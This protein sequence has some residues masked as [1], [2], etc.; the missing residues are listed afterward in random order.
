M[1]Y[2]CGQDRQR[3]YIPFFLLLFGRGITDASRTSFLVTVAPTVGVLVL[4]HDKLGACWAGS[5][6]YEVPGVE[7]SGPLFVGDKDD[8]AIIHNDVTAPAFDRVRKMV[9]GAKEMQRLDALGVFGLQ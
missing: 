5:N 8:E 2:I 1:R 4:K 3:P 6:T 9:E 7:F